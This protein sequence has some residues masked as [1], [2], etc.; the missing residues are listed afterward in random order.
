MIGLLADSA[1]KSVHFKGEDIPQYISDLVSSGKWKGTFGEICQTNFG[2]D[3]I[4]LCKLAGEYRSCKL[5]QSCK[6]I[7]PVNSA[8]QIQRDD[9][10]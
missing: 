2:S 6:Q 10:R 8:K 1:N 7:I 4:F 5:S 9:M 3:N